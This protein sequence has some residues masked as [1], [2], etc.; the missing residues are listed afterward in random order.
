VEQALTEHEQGRLAEASRLYTAALTLEATNAKALHMLGAVRIQQGQFEDAIRLI[1][2]AL[3]QAPGNVHALNDLG[4]A[5]ESTDRLD[6]A[7][8]HYKKA[9][10]IRPDDADT[11]F[12]LGAVELASGRPGDAVVSFTDA[13]RL[14]PDAPATLIHRAAAW[15]AMS[16]YEDALKDLDRA[17]I[18]NPN[19]AQAWYLRGCNAGMFGLV[20]EVAANFAK[21]RE[22]DPNIDY[23]LGAF[24]HAKADLCD[25]RHRDQEFSELIA[26]IS[27]ERHDCHPTV[28]IRLLDHPLHQ[29]QC[30]K[31]AASRLDALTQIPALP[32]TRRQ[33]KRI[34]VAYLSN[35]FYESATAYLISELFERHDRDRFELFGVSYGPEGQGVARAR[36]SRA[37]DRFIDVRASSD[38]EVATML[39]DLETDI[40]VD[41]MGYTGGARPGITAL[42]CAPIQVNYLVYPGTMGAGFIDYLIADPF[43]IPQGSERYYSEQVVRLPECYQPNDTKRPIGES[44][45]TRSEL[46]LPET[47]FVFCSFNSSYKFTPA[48]F[49]VW[50][51]LLNQVDGSVLWLL[52][53]NQVVATNLRSE[54]RQRG[55]APSRL[56]FAPMQPIDVH[57]ARHAAADLFLDSLPCNAHTTASDALW[58]GLPVLT[59]AGR[60]FAARVAGSLL[61]AVGL[62]QL[63][64]D[65]LSAYEALALALARDPVR[66]QRLRAQL[67]ANRATAP[68]FDIER[69]A[70]HLEWAYE[71][72]WG[73]HVRGKA[74]RAFDVPPLPR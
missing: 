15:N 16:R 46:G 72:M 41:L 29:L 66:L 65:N 62:C 70:R 36:I 21:A 32:S 17:L 68:L 42:R 31:L 73:Q 20:T 23:L 6:D 48:M 7:V 51:R 69:Y 35:R 12:R 44:T 40:A 27:A 28:A 10:A 26:S 4:F 64:T 52:S 30:A 33:R 74:P 59:C 50:M 53:P 55:I 39:R 71:A 61:R 56:V 11:L 3:A 58:A 67:R 8:A 18:L 54:A 38:R 19:D 2:L 34:R 60:S 13:L 37:V 43:V 57:L 24:V 45:L 9:L 25:W 5:F 14:N 49:D 63:L 22:L 47:G 1:S